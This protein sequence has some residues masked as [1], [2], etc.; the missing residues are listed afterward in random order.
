MF[1][2][3]SARSAAARMLVKSMITSNLFKEAMILRFIR[4]GILSGFYIAESVAI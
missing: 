3:L 2:Y 4:E 1:A